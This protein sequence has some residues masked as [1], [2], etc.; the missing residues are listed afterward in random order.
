MNRQDKLKE[1]ILRLHDGEDQETIKDEFKEHFEAVS[2]K[3]IS[4]M[5]KSLINEGI[6]VE[7][8]MKLCNVHASIM[9]KSVLQ[10]HGIEEEH[11]HPGH[12]IQV[13]KNENGALR[14][15]LVQMQDRVKHQDIDEL[16]H[17]SEKLS[18]IDRH[19]LRK[20]NSYFSLMEKYGITAPP[21]VMWGVDDEIRTLIKT[22]RQNLLKGSVEGYDEMQYEI[23]EMITKEEDIMLPMILDVFTQQDWLQIEKESEAIGYT[24]IHPTQKWIPVQSK[25][26][27]DRYREDQ[28]KTTVNE[29]Q[30]TFK[31]GSLSYKQL[32][33]VLNNLP[34]EVTFID[35][36]DS[37]VYFNESATKYFPRT[38]S[39][40]GRHVLNCHPPKSQGIVTGLLTD[41]KAGR[42]DSQTM[43]FS[44]GD[45]FLVVT[46][47]A[48]R[49][50]DGTYMGTLEYVQEVSEIKKMQ[51]DKRTAD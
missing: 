41:F 33:K 40:L 21:K 19:Y 30:L 14:M 38:Q 26:F 32:V 18:E 47:V 5:E 12:P 1:L 13:L 46:Y 3:E 45:L 10:I 48:I 8:I 43:W 50:E 31:T 27:V 24:I 25:S 15:L 4:E 42:K 39:A 2:A 51:G 6:E 28:N 20:E 9:G 23:L 37:F 35:E 17:L 11:Q 44:K 7:S 29:D 22:F 34:L 49:D 36:T 16:I